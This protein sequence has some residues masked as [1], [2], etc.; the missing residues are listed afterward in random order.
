MSSPWGRNSILQISDGE[1]LV[2]AQV[3]LTSWW[4]ADSRESFMAAHRQ[5]L[6][7]LL[8]ALPSHTAKDRARTCDDA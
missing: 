7:R 5:Q 1:R 6:P 4:I 8:V 3:N 2:P